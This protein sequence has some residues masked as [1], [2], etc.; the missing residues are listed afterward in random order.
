M[1][2]KDVGLQ[3]PRQ[4]LQSLW[5]ESV[6]FNLPISLEDAKKVEDIRDP[7]QAVL[8]SLLLKRL[9]EEYTLG[10]VSLSRLSLGELCQFALL[11]GMID[12]KG[13]DLAK[14]VLQFTFFSSFRYPERLYDETNAKISIA[15][16]QRAFGKKEAL[17]EELDPYFAALSRN[18]PCF[19]E[20]WQDIASEAEIFDDLIFS[21]DVSIENSISSN[22]AVLKAAFVTE[23]E[24]MPLGA[25]V[26]KDIEI[27][28]FG[29]QY[30]SLNRPELFGIDRIISD[31][32]WGR[33]YA[34]KDVWFEVKSDLA[35]GDLEISFYGCKS[36]NPLFFVFYI[37]AEQ[38][39]ID[40]KI[41]FPK[42]LDRYMGGLQTVILNR[43]KTQMSINGNG[44]SKMQLI[45]LAGEGCFWGSDFLL[46]FEAYEKL[47]FHFSL[48]SMSHV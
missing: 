36:E 23:G 8:S 45:P 11:Y 3:N 30:G 26:G 15:L 1:L 41:Y 17:S 25:F 39:V 38:V 34:Q 9:E 24:G 12:P 2:L 35:R 7:I 43:W 22:N 40:Q 4:H 27:P 44:T 42:S 37:R 18:L 13:K 47:V 10:D 29:P 6:L 14:K 20:K 32:K 5:A 31:R 16:L 19:E 46:A 28:A 33:V 48:Q 21:K